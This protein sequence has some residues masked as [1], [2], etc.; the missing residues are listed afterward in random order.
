M[1]FPATS[2]K[3]L[4]KASRKNELIVETGFQIQKDFAE[5]GLEIQFSGKATVFYDELFGQMKHHVENLMTESMERF[6]HFLYRI[7][8]SQK[9]I[10]HYQHEMKDVEFGEILTELIIHRELKKVITRDFFRQQNKGTLN[11]ELE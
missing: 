5:F 10:N 8:I 6:M 4:Q 9:D 11:K 7:D 2:R 1:N 3:D